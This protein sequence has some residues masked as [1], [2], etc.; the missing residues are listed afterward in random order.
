VSQIRAIL[1]NPLQLRA[2]VLGALTGAAL[3]L[4]AVFST[5]GPLIFLPYA[6]MFC[7]L[8]P[9]L[10][11]YRSET[12]LARAGAVFAAFLAATVLSYL[13]IR[14]FA[15]PGVPSFS[16]IGLARFGLVV[17]SGAVLAA[18]IAFVTGGDNPKHVGSAA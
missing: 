12:F 2:L 3:V 4:V 9:L 11:R 13:Y 15:N 1:Q 16:F 18:A 17:G 8:A 14:L 6:A 7:A 10:A 5:R